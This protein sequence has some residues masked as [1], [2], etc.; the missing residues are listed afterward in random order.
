M[1]QHRDGAPQ[2]AALAPSHQQENEHSSPALVI[3]GVTKFWGWRRR[4]RPVLTGVDL[5]L[6]KGT[7]AWI[8]GRNGAG[9]TTLLRL[10]GG[11][12][13]PDEGQVSLHG[14]TPERNRR[15]YQQHIGFLSAGDRGL[16]PR[17][18]VTRHLALWARLTFLPADRRQAAID[19]ALASFDLESLAARRVDRMSLGQR[20]RLRLS[21]AF[22][23]EP[24]LVL[25]DEP[26]NSLDAEGV[27]LLGTALGEHVA[28]GGMAVWCSPIGD[29]NPVAFNHEYLVED[30][31]LIRA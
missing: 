20:Q 22:M 15:R 21:L 31:R 28:R 30:G 13:A 26:R 1:L 27:A 6:T 18:T 7:S 5:E 11:L 4:G 19:R 23:H 17:L 10:A 2:T 29:P 3:E 14:L 8:G 24:E 9:K 16:Y 12:L 25:L